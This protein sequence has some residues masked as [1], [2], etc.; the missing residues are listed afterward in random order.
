MDASNID[1]SRLRGL[2]ERA[3][4]VSERKSRLKARY[5]EAARA[6]SAVRQEFEAFQR[7]GGAR[8]PWDNTPT[9]MPS[10]SA[11]DVEQASRDAAEALTDFQQ[12]QRNAGSVEGLAL[13]AAEYAAAALDDR[14][15]L[16]VRS[17]LEGGAGR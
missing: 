2:V 13:A 1:L 6:A 4:S 15:P 7:S 3:Q 10:P 12:A 16:L 9:E 14:T 5:Y 8:Q 11:A 17:Y